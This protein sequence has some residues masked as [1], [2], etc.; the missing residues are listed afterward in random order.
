MEINIKEYL[1]E[2]T[3][4][5]KE[6]DNFQFPDVNINTDKIKTIMINEVVPA[7]P[8]N[9]FYGKNESPDYLS[10]VF[11]LFQKA[12]AEVENIDDITS[13]GIY[14]TN[15]VKIPK[16]EY[17]ISKDLITDSLPFLEAEIELFPNLEVI[18]LMGDVAK[19]ALNM[20]S[21]KRTKTAVIPA[22]STYKLRNSE[23]WYGKIRVF[24]SY[25]MTGKNILIEKSKFEMA[26]DDIRKMLELI[27]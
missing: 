5:N 21:R 8:E 19:K 2:N 18:M 24:P 14:L 25:I 26:S 7:D 3:D 1:K 13:L 23:F 6:K 9:D 22:I 15:A 27:K 17:T 12:G 10:T 11:P 20:I 16:N 4:Y